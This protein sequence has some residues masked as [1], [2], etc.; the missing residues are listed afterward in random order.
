MTHTHTRQN[1]FSLVEILVVLAIT[2]ILALI[3]IPT[4]GAWLEKQ[5]LDL[6][7]QEIGTFLSR[8]RLL[9]SKRSQITRVTFSDNTFFL[10]IRITNPDGTT[11]YFSPEHQNAGQGKSSSFLMSNIEFTQPEELVSGERF[12]YYFHPNGIYFHFFP[13]S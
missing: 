10:E 7:T 2:G 8:A 6:N 13:N 4:F 11:S 9:S 5:R 1:G 12:E 3:L